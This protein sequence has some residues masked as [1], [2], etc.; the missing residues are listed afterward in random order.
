MGL[1][2]DV[3]SALRG[4]VN[5]AGVARIE[6]PS[7]DQDAAV[8]VDMQRPDGKPPLAGIL[9][10]VDRMADTI[11]AAVLALPPAE[12]VP[13]GWMMD[14]AGRLVRVANIKEADLLRDGVTLSLALEGLILHELLKRFKARALAEMA[15]VVATS[16][17]EYGVEMGGEKGNLSL[18]T[19][20]GTWLVQRVYRDVIS[21]S[22]KILAAKE[23]IDR[24][25]TRWSEGADP[26]ISALIDRAFRAS[27]KGDLRTGPVLELLR[28][29]ID[30]PEW[31]TAMTALADSID[32]TGSAVYVR[33]SRR[34]AGDRYIPVPI[35]LAV[36]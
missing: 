25:I 6:G 4:A 1:V 14:S 13:D 15:E 2:T 26:N 35:D 31:Q 30:D 18:S 17:A 3:L 36:V 34:I 10:V 11:A 20:D 29:K 9:A 16:A 27:K 5:E 23:L 22:E 7:D 8:Y 24:C 33:I 12:E 28:L 21:F 19:F 32:I